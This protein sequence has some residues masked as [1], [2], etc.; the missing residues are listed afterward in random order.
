MCVVVFG[1]SVLAFQSCGKETEETS[2]AEMTAIKE[3]QF[4]YS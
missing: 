1:Q 4:S 2:F 3:D